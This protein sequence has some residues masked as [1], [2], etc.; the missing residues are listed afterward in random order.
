[1]FGMGFGE[2]VQKSRRF[3]IENRRPGRPGGRPSEQNR[4]PTAKFERKNAP[5]APR[6]Q[7]GAFFLADRTQ[8]SETQPSEE[9]NAGGAPEPQY[10]NSRMDIA[11]RLPPIPGPCGRGAGVVYI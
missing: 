11:L 10:E 6:S 9:R 7:Q 3:G 4:G 2:N 5:G 1:M 8:G